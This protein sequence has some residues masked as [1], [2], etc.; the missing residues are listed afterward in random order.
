MLSVWT[1]GDFV[2]VE[3]SVRLS[4]SVFQICGIQ[5]PASSD[6][7][8]PSRLGNELLGHAISKT[9]KECAVHADQCNMI[10]CM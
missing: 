4:T 10:Q 1:H 5:S 6:D 3:M 7:L 8:H 2:F 9:E